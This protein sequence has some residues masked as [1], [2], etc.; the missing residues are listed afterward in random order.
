MGRLHLPFGESEEIMFNNCQTIDSSFFGFVKAM[1]RT[2]D[3]QTIPKHC[4][5]KDSRLTVPIFFNWTEISCF[6]AEI[7]YSIYEYQFI[8]GL[9]FQSG[10]FMSKFFIDG[11]DK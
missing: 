3:S 1:V 10:C 9:K 11:F 5:L 2:I 6:S 8:S 4:L 7:D